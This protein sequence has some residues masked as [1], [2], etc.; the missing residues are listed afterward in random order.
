MPSYTSKK[1]EPQQASKKKLQSHVKS[2][3]E[4]ENNFSA[5]QDE[6]EAPTVKANPKTK[7]RGTSKC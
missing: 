4:D 7:D 2:W 5:S 3:L 1:E 6:M